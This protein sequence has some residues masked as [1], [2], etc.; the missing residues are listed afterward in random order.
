VTRFPQAAVAV[1]VAA[2]ARRARAPPVRAR[3]APPA[4][5]P[6]PPRVLAALQCGE[7]CPAN[8][9]PGQPTLTRAAGSGRAVPWET[10]IKLPYTDQTAVR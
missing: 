2:Q 5:A 7:L 10:K 4:R 3:A 9:A 1:V 8:W 6:R